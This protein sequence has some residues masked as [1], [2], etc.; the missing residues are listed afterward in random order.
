MIKLPF[1]HKL[2]TIS[3]LAYQSFRWTPAGG[4]QKETIISYTVAKER[5]ICQTC[6]NDMQYGLPVGVRDKILAE[7]G[8]VMKRAPES[9][10]GARNHYALIA[11]GSGSKEDTSS[12]LTLTNEELL[13]S[14]A[15][16]KLIRLAQAKATQEAKNTVSFR[17]L[18]KLCSFWVLGTCKRCV[19]GVCQFRPCAGPQSFAFPE[20]ARTHKD[21]CT[22]LIE[23]LKKEGAT[24]VMNTMDPEVRKALQG[25]RR[26]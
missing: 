11:T 9:A 20:L 23:R 16:Q 19:K 7:V 26:G 18:P 4:R 5:N 3:G 8:H 21:I 15:G 13:Q 12:A 24:E 10:E 25:S 2:C 22:E 14:A 6:L 17:N 1:S